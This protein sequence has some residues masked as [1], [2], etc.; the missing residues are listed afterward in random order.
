MARTFRAMT[1]AVLTMSGAGNAIL[2]C[3]MPAW[4]KMV[5]GA[6]DSRRFC[7]RVRNPESRFDKQW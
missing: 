3:R 6:C 1:G 7:Y 2:Y 4:S 5:A